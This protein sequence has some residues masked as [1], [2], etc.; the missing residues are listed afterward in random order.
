[1]PKLTITPEKI[2]KVKDLVKRNSIRGA[3][4][5]AGISYY[6]ANRIVHGYYENE[7]PLPVK[8]N[9]KRCLITGFKN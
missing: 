4:K 5:Y 1:M 3:A 8:I 9:E 6:T 7:E 2:D